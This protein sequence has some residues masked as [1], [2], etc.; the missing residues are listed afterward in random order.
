MLPRIAIGQV[1]SRNPL[2]NFTHHALLTPSRFRLLE[3]FNGSSR[4]LV[5]AARCLVSF[6]VSRERLSGL[7][8]ALVYISQF[9]EGRRIVGSDLHR[10][11]ESF[12][13][14]RPL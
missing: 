10:L 14:G 2:A 8:V 13:G 4:G 11:F 6:F 9:E 1:A 12:G 3:A 7:F 5:F